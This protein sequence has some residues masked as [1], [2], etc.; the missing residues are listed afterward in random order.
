MTRLSY[1]TVE[2]VPEVD[3][4]L[5]PLTEGGHFPPLLEELDRL[6][7]GGIRSQLNCEKFRGL[8]GESVVLTTNGRYRVPRLLC[9][10]MG[11]QDALTPAKLYALGKR[12][13]AHLPQAREYTLAV[14]GSHLSLDHFLLA[15]RLESWKFDK[16]LTERKG[17][18]KHL[19]CISSSD[20]EGSF[21]EALYQGVTLAKKMGVEPANVMTPRVFAES[22]KQ[23]EG[24]GVKVSLLDQERLRALGL[25]GLLAVAQGSSQPPYLVTMEWRGDPRSSKTIALVGKGVCYD[26]GGINLKTEMQ[27]EMKWDKAGAAVVVGAMQALALLKPSLNVVGVVGLVE[28]M[29]DGAS[30][31]PGDIIRM[32]AGKTVEVVDT[33]CEGRLVLAD[34]LWY[35]Q[36]H[37][38]LKEL[39]DLATLTPDTCSALADAYAG[40]YCEDE[41]LLSELLQAGRVTGEG[42]WP[43]PRGE[44]FAEQ[45]RS[46]VADM[47]NSGIYQFGDCGAAA[48]FL[49]RFVDHKLPWAHIDI[50]GVS[51]IGEGSSKT[52]T[53]YGVRLLIEWLLTK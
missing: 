45:I 21:T 42:V 34:C 5:F 24:A 20:Q 22:C 25:N 18:L 51:W 35:A 11:P 48:E 53:G 38:D 17:S 7:E 9:I 28:N 26:S 14:D 10:G 15:L 49:S 40:L 12:V 36:H 16:Y 23:L 30:L 6:F 41:R 1:C 39:I 2:T 27:V 52:V 4:L 33:D 13:Q 43:L 47:K 29:P 50:A 19:F 32:A 46:T 8:A 31:K 44:V 37:F 3:L